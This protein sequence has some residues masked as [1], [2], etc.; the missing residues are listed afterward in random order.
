[1]VCKRQNSHDKDSEEC[2]LYS[3]F[4]KIKSGTMNGQ[5]RLNG[6]WSVARFIKNRV[7]TKPVVYPIK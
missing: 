6:C 2:K 5:K 3:S 1:M 4:I 7:Y